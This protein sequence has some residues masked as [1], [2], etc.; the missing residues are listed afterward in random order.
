MSGDEQLNC[1]KASRRGHRGVAIKLMRE[2]RSLM[3][4]ELTT[5]N[6]DR[7]KSISKVLE[8]KS[9][10][11]KELDDNILSIIPTE[12]IEEEI[13]Q[14][15]EFNNIISETQKVMAT[16]STVPV[17]KSTTG[18]EA[19]NVA[20]TEQ[21]PA[22]HQTRS[23]HETLQTHKVCRQWSDKSWKGNAKID[24]ISYSKIR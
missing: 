5:T 22:V 15:D 11:L 14:N 20:D 6:V 19:T 2:A 1:L 7:I 3:E 23:T 16:H 24:K 17:T 18:R 4:G 9:K 10:L 8:E 21:E 12:D 13:I